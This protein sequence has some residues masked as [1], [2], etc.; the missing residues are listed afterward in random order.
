MMTNGNQIFWCIVFL[1]SAISYQLDARWVITVV[2]FSVVF[3]TCCSLFIRLGNNTSNKVDYTRIVLGLTRQ[4][5]CLAKVVALVEQKACLVLENTANTT[6]IQTAKSLKNKAKKLAQIEGELAR[7]AIIVFDKNKDTAYG[8]AAL[9]RL[10]K[11]VGTISEIVE[12]IEKLA[13]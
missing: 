11:T 10:K 7:E 6:A 8:G 13:K 4:L 2:A 5:M 9:D 1:V 12:K 3:K